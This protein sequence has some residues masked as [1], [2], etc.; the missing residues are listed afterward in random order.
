ML[1]CGDIEEVH[2]T[3]AR[4]GRQIRVIQRYAPRERGR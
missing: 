2:R 3:I 1:E 4:E